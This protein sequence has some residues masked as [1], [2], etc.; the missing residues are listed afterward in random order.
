MKVLKMK[1]IL[2]VIMSIFVLNISVYSN[3]THNNR[4]IIKFKNNTNELRDWKNSG[5][6]SEIDAI[7]SIVGK[8]KIKPYIDNKL[9]AMLKQHFDNYYLLNNYSISNSL[10]RIAYVEIEP[11]DNL[12]YLVKKI[13]SLDFIQ[14]AELE[15]ISKLNDI[16]NDPMIGMQYYLQKIHAIEAWEFLDSTKT[17]T[18]GIVDTGID[19]THEDIK[20]N[21]Y[22]NLGEMG[23]DS[24]NADKSTNG[25]DDDANGYIDDWRGWDFSASSD[26]ID[27]EDNDPMPGNLHG[28]H[29]G[30]TIGAIINNSIGISPVAKYVK[31]M[32]VKAA[33]DDS[34]SKTM[35]NSYQALLYAALKGAKVINC[36]WGST[37][38]SATEEEMVKTAQAA[39][40][41]IVAAA[42]NDQSYVEQYPASYPDVFSV[43][44]TDSSDRKAYFSNYHSTIDIAAP[45]VDIWATIPENGYRYLDG[46]SMAT[47]IVA[48]VTAMTI[49]K[50]PDYTPIQIQEHIKACSDN[51]DSLDY[52]Y[53]GKI[54]KGR[55][56]AYKALSTSN[57]KSLIISNY[58]FIETDPDYVYAPEEQVILKI[59]L[60]N[61]LSKIDN[62]SAKAY[63][64][65][66][67]FAPKFTKD[68]AFVGNLATNE[69][70]DTIEFVFNIPW[71]ASIDGDYEI[72]IRVE[73]ID[74]NSVFSIPITVN[75]SYRT[76]SENNIIATLNSRGNLGFNDYPSNKQ[77]FGFKYKNQASI[78]FEGAVLAAN[79]PMQM[80]DVAR[81]SY[82]MMQSRDFGF[83]KAIEAKTKSQT[84]VKYYDM[85]DSTKCGVAINQNAYQFKDNGLENILILDFDVTNISERFLDSL[86]I[87]YFFDWDII[88]SHKNYTYYD[89]KNNIGITQLSG[90]DT[91]T[92]I[93]V[94]FLESQKTN[95]RAIDNDG[96]SEDNF[97]IYDGFDNYEK[98]T[99]LSSGF[100]RSQ[101]S[102]TDVSMVI[103]NG[104]HKLPINDTLKLTMIIAADTS[105]KS[106][107]NSIIHARK[108]LSKMQ[109]FKPRALFS[110]ELKILNLYPN[111]ISSILNALILLPEAGNYKLYISDLNGKIKKEII[112]GSTNSGLKKVV[113]VDTR[114]LAQGAYILVL[115][116]NGKQETANFVKVGTN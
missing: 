106:M 116:H 105:I 45:G 14:Y 62:I 99:S 100:Q 111:P 97:G 36:S 15:P 72:K 81:A 57:S 113:Q 110:N 52:A 34:E 92:V 91:T 6:V 55:I 112:E 29:V 56:N 96:T 18:V 78:L 114:E 73:G 4:F 41:I 51:I 58:T 24:N 21:I 48:A 9:L 20:D 84:F 38:K 76:M 66:F 70:S 67:M 107:S 93:G 46:T 53:A 87:G 74:Y 39:G 30:G 88:N 80:S 59:N 13:E 103:S 31:L 25:I 75:Q 98:W 5:R 94:A 44:A 101:S 23:L 11:S 35:S 65:Y 109:E 19:Y 43:A 63:S 7:K 26:T 83:D 3:D 61:I 28:T 54:G 37:S 69:I 40:A 32:P 60:K 17:I 33:A 22:N 85:A 12:P 49:N 82:Q 50:F 27:G 90:S 102:I 108:V 10:E 115:E 79:S 47:P 2:F 71:D 64:D 86:F 42:G 8:H 16:P 77:G 95:F 1:N 89:K 104:P 68:S